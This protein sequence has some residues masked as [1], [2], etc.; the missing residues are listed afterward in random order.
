MDVLAPD[1]RDDFVTLGFHVFTEGGS[2]IVV[3]ATLF[4]YKLSTLYLLVLPC[5]WELSV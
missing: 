5:Q 1:E 2:V 4:P 3:W